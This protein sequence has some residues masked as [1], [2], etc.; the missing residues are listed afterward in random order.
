MSRRRSIVRHGVHIKGGTVDITVNSKRVSLR[1]HYP[2]EEYDDIRQLF[3]K[4]TNLSP[5][6]ER[7]TLLH[8]FVE[9]WEFEGDPH[10]VACWSK[11]D[12]F[13]EFA[14][15]EN[16]VAEFMAERARYSK[17]LVKRSIMP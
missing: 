2:V 16:A 11:L 4:L 7:A 10:D 15:I 3:A 1:E 9:S 12:M 13:S 14:A 8:R 6:K 5:W 17:N